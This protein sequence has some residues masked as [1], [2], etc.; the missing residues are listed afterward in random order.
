MEKG[1]DYRGFT[2]QEIVP[3]PDY[4]SR[5]IWLKHERTG[6]E[7]FHLLNDDEE[8]LF[9][10]AF[11]TLPANS[12]GAPHIIEHSV[13]CG[14]K[15]YPLK[16]PFIRLANQSVK[17]FLNAM[18]YP[19]KTVY[20]A[21][22]M[23]ETDYF[24]LMAVYAD[25]VFFPRLEK[26]TFL[27]E[28]RRLAFDENGTLTIQG[29][30]YNEMKG[31]Y[32]SFDSVAAD[33]VAHSL[34][35]GTLYGVD[36]GGDPKEIPLLTY[37]RFKEF[38]AAFY[39]P[40]NCLLFL[41][42][43]IPTEKQLDFVDERVIAQL[44]ARESTKANQFF[45]ANPPL[46]FENAPLEKPV[47]LE[48]GAPA[49]QDAHGGESSSRGGCTVLVNWLLGNSFDP[50]TWMESVFLDEALMGHDAS[51]LTKALTD[52][53]LG[54]DIAPQAGLSGGY[55]RFLLSAGLRGVKRN[56]ARKVE[57]LVFETLERLAR[58]SIP[59]RDIKA[60]C[61][62][63]DFSQRE[64]KR[65]HGPY[66]LVLMQRVLQS[67]VH[68]GNP[69]DCLSPRGAFAK[70]KERIAQ[71]AD[72]V[73]SLVRSLLNNTARSLVT[74][75]A[76]PAY[77]ERAEQAEKQLVQKLLA[78]TSINEVKREQKELT[79]FQNDSEDEKKA[80]C[81]PHLKPSDLNVRVD[82]IETIKTEGA[83][84]VPVFHTT[85]NTNGVVYV[86]AAFPLDTLS[87]EDFQLLPVFCS[88]LSNTGFDGKSWHECANDIALT[89]GG[90]NASAY[91]SSSAQKTALCDSRQW[92]FVQVK[93]LAEKTQESL[94]LLRRCLTTAEFTD[95]KRLTDL[96]LEA[97]N[98]MRSSIIPSGHEFAIL[99]TKRFFSGA[100]ALDEIWN[101]V[102][103]LFTLNS[104]IEQ[105]AESLARNLRRV[106][107]SLLEAGT[108][109][110]V[111][112]DSAFKS[113]EIARFIQNA[114]LRPPVP[115]KQISFNDF[116]PLTECDK[117]AVNANP[118]N[119]ESQIEVCL[120]PSQVGCAAVSFS[121]APYGTAENAHELV[122]AN[123]FSKTMLWEQIRTVGGAYGAFAFP[124]S[125]EKT[126]TMATYRDPKPAVSLETFTACL[127][128]AS[129]AKLQNSVVERA[130]CGAYSNEVQPLSPSARG[131]T[132]FMR[133]L[134]GITDEA[135]QQK[136]ERIKAATARDIRITAE[137]LLAAAQKQ[138]FETILGG[139]DVQGAVKI[140]L[141]F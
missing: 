45:A 16:D 74:V 63:V 108:V 32:S 75:Y 109:I 72:Y 94:D 127:K 96:L 18:T 34:F 97:R 81:L 118:L 139:A 113:D 73:R 90:F 104:L 131:F 83:N 40:A 124:D 12:S 79:R 88:A 98:D 105:G 39:R 86:I 103:Q 54:E 121:A 70:I 46:P 38:H 53:G 62:A 31:A 48:E 23:V 27:Q 4:S 68:G 122:F 33:A 115:Q 44:E 80:S 66:S 134:Y 22:S 140:T 114:G 82:K 13:L 119:A 49:P 2:A 102:S 36:S 35:A 52:S 56:D 57:A 111:T 20:P 7:V 77:T 85:E 110:H 135:R 71:D 24:N 42:G 64:I 93:M 29:V 137:R 8:N 1:G 19:D 117:A 58:D 112:A 60:A 65:A 106:R 138:K 41:Y 15:H 59:E 17:T 120:A 84:G 128:K 99:R 43:N 89:M 30:V 21:S 9:A 133:A 101:G 107:K 67:W 130:V 126:F 123:W 14:S 132:G 28:G 3:V 125:L 87:T 47:V 50:L 76:D 100:K 11:R 25:A 6:L 129:A 95:S 78:Q 26:W 136:I 141:P 61:M 69:W 51:P 5:G 55:R 37:E 92:L 91:V 116:F 10:F